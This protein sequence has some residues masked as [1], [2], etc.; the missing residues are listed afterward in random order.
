MSSSDAVERWLV[1]SLASLLERDPQSI[2]PHERFTHYGLDSAGALGLVSELG[3]LLGRTL[4]ATLLW[5]RP[6][7]ASVAVHLFAAP[8]T[9]SHADVRAGQPRADTAAAEE[10]IA[11]VGIGCRFPGARDPQA[12]WRLL[13]DGI[14]AVTEVPIDRWD[15]DAYFDPDLRAPGKM[16]TRWGGF[17]ERID[18]F[19]AAFFGISPREALEMD[20]QQR[21]ML[22]VAW[23]ALED[24]GQ[25]PFE[26]K[27]SRTGVFFGA[28]W[29]DY[30]A[31][32]QRGDARY[33]TTHTAT[34]AHYSIIANRLSYVL[35]L[36]GPSMTIDTACSSSLVAIHLACQSLRTGESQL[37]LAGGVTLVAAPESTIAMSKLGAMSPDGR[38]R[39]FDASGSGYVR[40]EGA[41]VV[42]L[43]RL[44]SALASGDRIYAVIRGSAVNNDG[45]S[46][47][48]TAPN[49][50]AQKQMLRDAYRRAH[51]APKEVQYIEAHGTG[52]PLGD[53]IE[54]KALGAVLGVDRSPE[55]PCLIGSVKTN[56]GHLEAAAGV[57]GLIKILLAMEHEELP[58]SLHF[59][60]PNPHIPFDELR[61]RVLRERTAW[62]PPGGGPRLAG[63]SSF[64]FGGTNC[65]VVVADVPQDRPHVIPLGARSAEE[66]DAL[67]R[68]LD[69]LLSG[70]SAS[71]EAIARS[72]AAHAS[73]GEHRLALTASSVADA[74]RA[75]AQ[76]LKGHP[77]PAVSRGAGTAAP[78][79]VFVCSGHG[80]QWA[81]MG[82]EA[83]QHEPAFRAKLEECDEA[84]RPLTGWSVLEELARAEPARLAE[85]DV[86][87]PLLFA[88]QVAQAELWRAW[89]VE[90]RAVIG[91]SIGEVA[92]AHLAGILDLPDAARVICA[93]SRLIREHASGRGRLAVIELPAEEIPR[94]AGPLLERLSIAAYNGPTTTVLGGDPDA[95][96]E[97]VAQLSRQEIFCQL[98]NIDYASHTAHMEFLRAP[99][100]AELAGLETRRAVLPMVSTVATSLQG[101]ARFDAAYW[102]SNEQQPVQFWQGIAELVRSGHD[103]FIE[104]GG[105]PVLARSINA[106]I[107]H[108]GANGHAL[109]SSRRDDELRTMLEGVGALHARGAR[110][111]WPALYPAPTTRFFSAAPPESAA[112]PEAEPPRTHIFTLSAHDEAALRA[113]AEATLAHL[114]R[115]TDPLADLCYTSNLRRSHHDA[116]LAVPCRTV[117]DLLARLRA[118]LQ[119]QEPGAR[120]ATPHRRPK[121][122]FV[123][124]GQGGQWW[125]M[126]H[127]LLQDEPVFRRAIDACD[128]A[129][130][131]WTGWSL[132]EELQRD[133]AASR[134]G[135]IDVAQPA[136]FAIQVALAALWRSWGIVP[137]A[138]VGHS[139]GEVAAAHV[140]GA[141]SLADAARVIC[142]RSQ[143]M[144]RVSGQGAMAVVELSRDEALRVIADEQEHLSVAGSNSPKACVLSGD[145]AALRRVLELLDGKEVFHRMLRVDVA[146]H[147]PQM[148]PLKNELVEILRDIAPRA[149]ELALFSSVTT[150]PREGTALDAAYWGRN[151]RD[152]F[153]FDD[154]IRQMA[155][156]GYSLFVELGPHPILSGAIG[157][158]QQELKRELVTLPSLKREEDERS[159]MLGTLAALYE[160]K[161]TPAWRKLHP[162]GG[163][164]VPLP[165]YQWQEERFWPAKEELMPASRGVAPHAAGAA[166][167]ATS[168]PT[169][170]VAR[171]GAAPRGPRRL[172][173]APPIAGAAAALSDF[174]ELD[175]SLGSH[176]YLADHVVQGEV[177]VPGTAQ[178]E[179][180]FDAARSLL[181]EGVTISE[182]TFEKALFLPAGTTRT[183]QV[184]VAP[185]ASGGHVFQLSSRPA[186]ATAQPAWTRHASG[187][188]AAAPAAEPA[189]PRPVDLAAIQGRLTR[190]A[191]TTH[192]ASLEQLG[193]RYGPAFRGLQELWRTD[194]EVLGL[195]HRPA[196]LETE[197]RTSA[198]HP[199]LLDAALLQAIYAAVP[200]AQLAGAAGDTFVPT[201]IGRFRMLAP[202]RER[203]WCHARLQP[204]TESNTDVFV[205]DLRILDEAGE[206]LIEGDGIRFQRLGG[207]LAAGGDHDPA[208]W[209]YD[210]AW[211][212]LESRLGRS[213]TPPTA[214]G[215]WI[216]FI[217]RSGR[218]RELVDALEAASGTCLCIEAGDEADWLRE[219]DDAIDHAELPI[220]G[221]VHLWGF[222]LPERGAAVAAEVERTCTDLVRLVQYLIAR[223]T[224]R[225]RLWVVTRGAQ[226]VSPAGKDL[227]PGQASLWGLGRVIDAEHPGVWGG[228]IDIG[229]DGAD[230]PALCRELA[231]PGEETQ[232]GFRAGKRFVL[233][234]VR[235]EVPTAGPL[236]CRPD[237]TYLVTGGLGGVGLEV[238][239]W[240]VERGARRLVLLGRTAFP[241]RMRW[242]DIHP[243]PTRVQIAAVRALERAGAAVTV[244]QADVGDREQMREVF[245]S[246]RASAPL[247]RGVMHA[248]GAIAPQLIS[249][250]TPQ[251]M[252]A[253]FRS[254]VDGTLILDE[255]LR[256]VELDFLVL[257]SSIESVIGMRGQAPYAAANAFLDMYAHARRLAGLSAVAIHWGMWGKIGLAA[258]EREKQFLLTHGLLEMAPE[259]ALD[260]LG[261]IIASGIPERILAAIDW[262]VFR[263]AFV[264]TPARALYLERIAVA[265]R[266]PVAAPA[267]TPESFIGQLARTPKADRV[268]QLA[269]HLQGMIAAVLRTPVEKLDPNRALNTVGLDSILAAE[270][271]NRIQLD[272]GVRVQMLALLRG[273]TIVELAEQVH[274]EMSAAVDTTAETIADTSAGQTAD[275]AAAWYAATVQAAPGGPRGAAPP[276]PPTIPGRAITRLAAPA[277]VPAGDRPYHLR[278]S[279]PGILNNLTWRPLRRRRPGYGEVEIEVQAAGL[280][281]IDVLMAMGLDPVQ[282]SGEPVFGL[283]C[284]GEIT[285]VGDGIED[286]AVGD[287]VIAAAVGSLGS[288]VMAPA[289]FVTH[290]PE[291][292]SEDD[293]ASIPIA[294]MTAHYA[295]HHLAR[296]RPGERVLIHSAAGGTGLACV[297]LAQRAGAEVFATAGSPEKRAYLQELGIAHVMD[298][299]TLAFAD[300]VLEHTGGTGI[301]VVINSLTGDAMNKSFAT[302]GPYGRFVEIGKRDI[303]QG[304]AIGLA[305]FR[306]S[307]SYF[308][309]DLLGMTL[310][311]P[312]LFGSLLQEVIDLVEEGAIRAVPTTVFPMSKAVEA[313][314]TM[315]QARHIGKLVLR[316]H[317]PDVKLAADDSAPALH[318]VAFAPRPPATPRPVRARQRRAPAQMSITPVQGKARF[319]PFPFTD[320]QYSY[321]VGRQGILPWGNIGTHIYLEI[322]GALDPERLERAWQKMLMQHDML[323]A[324]ILPLGEQQ[325]PE[326]PPPYKIPVVD[327]RGMPVI[328]QQSALERERRRMSTS[329][330]A[331]EAWPHYEL[332]LHILDDGRTRLHANLDMI[333]V[334]AFSVDLLFN[335]WGKLYADPD[336]SLPPIGVSF[337]DYVLAEAAFMRGSEP[338]KRAEEYWAQRMNAL[339]PPP[340]LPS[341]PAP[342]S[343]LLVRPHFNHYIGSLEPRRWQALKT[344]ATEAGLTPSSIMCAAFAEILCYWSKDARFTINLTQFRRFPLHP[345]V[346]KII[347]DF[348]STILLEIDWSSDTAFLGR[349]RK[350]TEQLW[351]DMDHSHVSGVRVLRDLAK[352][353]R[354]PLLMPVVF[355]SALRDLGQSMSWAGTMGYFVTETSQ[356]YLDNRIA[357]S[358]GAL[359]YGWD[360]LEEYFPPGVLAAMFQSYEELIRRLADGDAHAWGEHPRAMAVDERWQAM[361]AINT[362]GAPLTDDLMHRLGLGHLRA[363]PQHP[364]VITPTRTLSYEEL[365]RR[366]RQIGHRL[367][368]LGARPNTLVAVVTQPGWERIV[369]ALGVL[370]SGAA[371]LPIDPT[372]P[373]E[374]IAY[375]LENGEVTLA[376]TPSW[377]DDGLAWPADV[378][379]IRIDDPALEEIDPTPLPPV[380]T[381]DDL[382]YVIFTSGSTGLPKGVMIDH[383][384]AVNTI[385]DINERFRVSPA[386]RV[387][388]LSNLSFDLS[389]YDI[390]GMLAAGGTIVMP[391]PTV[392]REPSHWAK[393][394]AAHEVTIWNTVPQL[395]Q[396]L[397]DCPGIGTGELDVSSL[398]LAMLS[399]DWI[400][401][402]LPPRAR[403]LVG[404]LEVV[405]L[406]GATEA[407]IWS[408]IFPIG[409]IDPTWRS[410]PYGRPMVNQRFYVLND[411]LEPCP[412]WVT[413]NLYIGGVGLAKG[414]WRD[415]DRTN[416]AFIHH[417]RTGERLYRT[418]DLGRYMEDGVIEFLGREDAQVKINGFR[419]ELGEIESALRQHPCVGDC[420]V[421]A[422]TWRSWNDAGTGTSIEVRNRFLL[423][424]VVCKA[425]TDFSEPDIRSYLK[426]KIPEFMV[427]SRILEIDHIPLSSNGKVDRRQ[428]PDPDA[429]IRETGTLLAPRTDLERILVGMW[430]TTLG[431]AA[432]KIGVEDNFFDL[433]GNSLLLVKVSGMIAKH[434]SIQLSVTQLF[435]SPTVESLARLLDGI[436]GVVHEEENAAAAEPDDARD[437]AARRKELRA[438]LARQKSENE[439]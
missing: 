190:L 145:P 198:F 269:T 409:E 220:R 238:A 148:E 166:R 342:K 307:L 425:G 260:H 35:G 185:S 428:L 172:A 207:S 197:P 359:V 436:R 405:S 361:A 47:G 404:N 4:P 38:S 378:Q 333:L 319:E 170:E 130:H 366:A 290:R 132:R 225:P 111:R 413:G 168:D 291:S 274:E 241:D 258:A 431:L 252:S 309:V 262:R 96:H 267:A 180:A 329:V 270:V 217:D 41:G 73:R 343:D 9:E 392:E 245:E 92:A 108:A 248:A 178:L 133:E 354:T 393:L 369:A 90:P 112:A 296:I 79:V 347:G 337:R 164:L 355:T 306:K 22:E 416:A 63:V 1:E 70:D 322:D 139:M 194:G 88:L 156:S 429:A 407:S 286:L 115:T 243:Q 215:T 326:Q 357:E 356:V 21:I 100:T 280:N 246:L 386:D 325:I 123:F 328:V 12:F 368:E 401:L 48:L 61:L 89:G 379:R 244:V 424:Y 184:A 320:I 2:D 414:Y 29:N 276:P 365:F 311:R 281:F 298:S 312:D 3:K 255:L 327:L 27:D 86:V 196:E 127:Q 155:A 188:I 398:R 103:T 295:L 237:G 162:R 44:S 67:A 98:V 279:S 377:L 259:K 109:P 370:E 222:D 247:L 380:Q 71:L 64:G 240:L 422:R 19:D 113:A 53:P 294:F 54:A 101:G 151:L 58:P 66:L 254:K 339:P 293:A 324:V 251:T 299:R 352:S 388:A 231:G 372:L 83:L 375:L 385:R 43:K 193:L 147:S 283:E 55:Q 150:Q 187:R 157:D 195:V 303:Y 154:T 125:K 37:A 263:T 358:N 360:V 316:G 292:L 249:G 81:G 384:G 159:V 396:M 421:L 149:G 400:P 165:T 433:G 141:L 116:R 192:Y 169:R 107:A 75:L 335:D 399:G 85:V 285:A 226:R 266:K 17:L 161:L 418:G 59:N 34:G 304:T 211:Q 173:F 363:R 282:Q 131:P 146:S 331:I 268:H 122:A 284:A 15:I 427:P 344:R 119:E 351:T 265:P 46:N 218:G 313:F 305:P 102:A 124:Q 346:N 121:L 202:L 174:W 261:P 14:D 137:D 16:T 78:R 214:T 406:G 330:P 45:Y 232:V 171:D 426:Q 105:H 50:E 201:G 367:R 20:P 77:H 128:A 33:I 42:V 415:E 338:S 408:I 256:G 62:R 420:Y 5:D 219:L 253:I 32:R 138:V 31:L 349:A 432:E 209:H 318:P 321:W 182:I 430:S 297:Q 272:L 93:R 52:T 39:A 175:I 402:D 118:F 390:F 120:R 391:D 28:L 382:A 97:L 142:H 395:L 126:G 177:T 186:D 99:L 51:L 18:S 216:I 362:T 389:V 144:K 257:F 373:N 69:E 277:L 84:I 94:I 36:Q 271:R 212:P 235:A 242:D 68:Q 206:T 341:H 91:H 397:A 49:P 228:L 191:A 234:F 80:S 317:D 387:L 348:T 167:E 24:A 82:R 364:A 158:L 300:T 250:L 239:R 227:A 199:A 221:V 336:Q 224:R 332:L 411:R 323:R 229:T 353:R 278:I 233:R 273:I 376:L 76:H 95:V 439:P 26:L 11:I 56:I 203:V 176:P 104:L 163:R 72:A 60:T 314:H 189:R 230:F 434:F 143:L 57:A 334:D 152:P 350:L 200:V 10:P 371:Y 302:L 340:Q 410:I 13:R 110:L 30:A 412:P 310:D 275:T 223:R 140:A 345:D 264:S 315:A 417:P 204:A 181:G 74:R 23:E 236:R 394:V 381:P 114:E 288:H 210:V 135:E 8:A 437:R 423:A 435:Q 183:I 106:A 308:A 205:A 129:M 40:G 65:H 289:G 6:T 287:P 208:Q 403:S 213:S 374:R 136:T 7:I 179:L 301:D 134:I 153:L 438:R 117:E 419:I 87:Q 160:R 383:R 25:P